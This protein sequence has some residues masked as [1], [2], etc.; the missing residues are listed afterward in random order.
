MICWKRE[1][2]PVSRHQMP[3]KEPQKATMVSLGVV[4]VVLEASRAMHG[5]AALGECVLCGRI[6]GT[7]RGATHC[8]KRVRWVAGMDALYDGRDESTSRELCCA[9]VCRRLKKRCPLGLAICAG[10]VEDCAGWHAHNGKCRQQDAVLLSFKHMH[11]L[12]CC[13]QGS[14][15]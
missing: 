15:V 11:A 13:K 5:S 3:E 2:L 14:G 7:L 1:F 8:S 4:G 12:M 9:F 6:G 10:S